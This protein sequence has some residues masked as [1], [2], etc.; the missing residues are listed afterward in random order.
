M[1][2]VNPFKKGLSRLIKS[3]LFTQWWKQWYHNHMAIDSNFHKDCGVWADVKRAFLT[4]G[5]TWEHWAQCHHPSTWRQI[6]YDF[7]QSENS[8]K[9]IYLR[10]VIRDW[11]AEQDWNGE[12]WITSTVRQEGWI[13]G[14]CFHQLLWLMM[15]IANAWKSP[16]D[17][18]YFVHW[19]KKEEAHM[20]TDILVNLT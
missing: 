11:G 20:V 19:K 12:M 3:L 10:V 8:L 15:I 9:Q 18:I 5:W 6:L 16:G 7:I 4:P 1:C 17:Y 14:V 13:L 2:Q